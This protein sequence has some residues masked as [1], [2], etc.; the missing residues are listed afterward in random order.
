M[1]EQEREE[2]KELARNLAQ[3][4]IDAVQ[5]STWAAKDKGQFAGQVSG[6]L[7]LAARVVLQQ[8]ITEGDEDHAVLLLHACLRQSLEQRGLL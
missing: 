3:A 4:A 5:A 7:M 2:T 6:V 8:S 1:N